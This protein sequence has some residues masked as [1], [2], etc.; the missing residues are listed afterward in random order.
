MLLGGVGSIWSPVMTTFGYSLLGIAFIWFAVI[1]LRAL[2]ARNKVSKLGVRVPRASLSAWYASW[3]FF[4]AF[5]FSLVFGLDP[6]SLAAL[7]LLF[8]AFV[9][10]L[11]Y[12][13][14]Y[15]LFPLL[16]RRK[17]LSE[18]LAMAQVVAAILG[19]FLMVFAFLG[20]LSPYTY[21]MFT[22]LGIGG[23][24]AAIS[25]IATPKLMEQFPVLHPSKSFSSLLQSCALSEHYAV[26]KNHQT[27]N[28]ESR[29]S[30]SRRGRG[31][32]P[33]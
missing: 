22:L 6:L 31:S 27:Q 3:I 4:L 9:T 2:L 29:T 11:V 1:Y 20:M 12:G 19:A 15:M 25:A 7:H 23:T 5:G 28:R 14:G 8:L 24:L 32:Y 10:N 26:M 33:L 17:T 30:D 21:R 13:V 16:L 18:T